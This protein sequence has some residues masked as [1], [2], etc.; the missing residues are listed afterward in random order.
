MG[1]YSTADFRFDKNFQI[2]KMNYTATLRIENVFDT[3]NINSVYETTGLPYT[4]Q[5]FNGQ[6]FTGLPQ[7]T[8]PANYDPG[9]QLKVGLSMNF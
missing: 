9:R 7:D 2:W 4:N 8:S 6:I 3:R 5:N 1:F